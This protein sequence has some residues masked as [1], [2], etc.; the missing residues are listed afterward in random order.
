MADSVPVTPVCSVLGHTNP[1]EPWPCPATYLCV[2]LSLCLW[3]ALLRDLRPSCS[4]STALP[5]SVQPA[6]HPHSSP[7]HALLALHTEALPPPGLC[8]HTKT[9]HGSQRFQKI[10]LDAH[11]VRN[12]CWKRSQHEVSG[13]KATVVHCILCVSDHS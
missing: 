3:G 9:E 8:P 7:S 13:S 11:Q 2:S 10:L 6:M 12:D 1:P 5:T 4:P